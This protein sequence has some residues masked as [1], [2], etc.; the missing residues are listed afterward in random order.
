[1]YISLI[2]IFIIIRNILY[3]VIVTIIERPQQRSS[4]DCA[5]SFSRDAMRYVCRLSRRASTTHR[6]IHRE[7]ARARRIR[8]RSRS[9][10]GNIYPGRGDRRTKSRSTRARDTHLD[11]LDSAS[12]LSC[13]HLPSSYDSE[14]ASKSLSSS[15][16]ASTTYRFRTVKLVNYKSLK[17]KNVAAT[18]TSAIGSLFPSFVFSLLSGNVFFSSSMFFPFE[19]RG[20]RHRCCCRM[21]I[22]P[23]AFLVNVVGGL[24]LACLLTRLSESTSRERTGRTTR[25][26]FPA[27]RNPR[28]RERSLVP[29]R[30]ESRRRARK[31]LT[32]PSF[33]ALSRHFDALRSHLLESDVVPTKEREKKVQ[34]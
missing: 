32:S 18:K 34:V 19:R 5:I 22:L 27:S 10:P 28:T 3:I 13:S 29:E 26:R 12:S 6:V 17:R 11:L 25:R 23:V 33:S 8:N 15:R 14:T 21:S 1:M 30:G 20:V 31:G 9:H 2:I 4:E 24:T 7:I 16:R